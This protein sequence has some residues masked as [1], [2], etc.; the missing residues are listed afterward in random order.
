[1]W[2]RQAYMWNFAPPPNLPR[3]RGR[4]RDTLPVHGEGWGGGK[5]P[6]GLCIS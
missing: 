3:E 1:M 6:H 4:C 5:K 2:Y